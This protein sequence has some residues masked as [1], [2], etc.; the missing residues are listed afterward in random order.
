MDH[1]YNVEDEISE[2]QKLIDD[3]SEQVKVLR[4]EIFE[5]NTKCKS[6]EYDIEGK[7]EK[8]KFQNTRIEEFRIMSE[9]DKDALNRLRDKFNRI[10]RDKE[11]I[12]T[13]FRHKEK[14]Y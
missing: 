1:L 4:Q 12:E 5:A 14:Q 8:L 7:D 13:T 10:S 9:R 6:L 2:S 11:N 3:L